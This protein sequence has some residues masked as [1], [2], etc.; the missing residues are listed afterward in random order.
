MG[1]LTI[2]W[3]IKWIAG[4]FLACVVKIATSMPPLLCIRSRRLVQMNSSLQG[5]CKFN[6]FYQTHA[7]KMSWVHNGSEPLI[8]SMIR[9]T[10]DYYHY[11]YVFGS[12]L[13]PLHGWQEWDASGPVRFAMLGLSRVHRDN[14][15]CSFVNKNVCKWVQHVYYLTRSNIQW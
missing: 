3:K 7:N 15:K 8:L 4:D 6:N 11:W 14:G 13:Q 5:C 2:W 12:P 9:A 10:H 1:T